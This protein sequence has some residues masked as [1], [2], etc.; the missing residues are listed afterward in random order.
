MDRAGAD[1]YIG[2][3]P[4]SFKVVATGSA[5]TSSPSSS[6][7]ARTLPAPIN[8]A[9]AEMKADGTLKALDKKWF[10]DYKIAN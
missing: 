7:R 6:R 1:G 2:A 4:D 5:M 9:L 10:Y 3:S 8:A